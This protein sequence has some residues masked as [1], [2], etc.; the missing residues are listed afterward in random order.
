MPLISD[1]IKNNAEKCKQCAF[2]KLRNIKLDR[3]SVLFDEALI[4]IE[5]IYRASCSMCPF[6]KDFEKVYGKKPAEYFPMNKAS[7][8]K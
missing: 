6:E 7:I 8:K 1:K 2:L 5:G 3:N 4:T